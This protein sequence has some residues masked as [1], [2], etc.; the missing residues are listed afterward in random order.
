[1]EGRDVGLWVFDTCEGDFL[2]HEIS[3]YHDIHD[4]MGEWHGASPTVMGGVC[5]PVVSSPMLCSSLRS[6]SLALCNSSM[7]VHDASKSTWNRCLSAQPE[8]QPESCLDQPWT[9]PPFA[10]ERR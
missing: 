10:E 8:P 2:S 3:G 6:S 4:C 9:P 7:S 5:S 1:V